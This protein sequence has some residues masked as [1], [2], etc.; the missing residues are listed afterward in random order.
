MPIDINNSLLSIH[1]YLGGKK[2]D[3]NH[4]STLVDTGA[5]MNIGI[6]VL[7]VGNILVS[8][9]CCRVSLMHGGH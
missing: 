9:N 1:F 8:K 7:F 2:D 3:D 5:A 6:K 4:M